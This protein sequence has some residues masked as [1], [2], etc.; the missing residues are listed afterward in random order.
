M[1]FYVLNWCFN[2][3]RESEE[4]VFDCIWCLVTFLSLHG[5]FLT[6]LMTV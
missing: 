1:S 3:A 2:R 6:D 4:L 5:H